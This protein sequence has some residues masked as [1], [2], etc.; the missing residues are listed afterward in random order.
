MRK[1]YIKASMRVIEISTNSFIAAS[2]RQGV[3]SWNE[4]YKKDDNNA[5]NSKESEWGN[6]WNK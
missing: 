4:L 6:T 2:A 3:G 1:N 5:V